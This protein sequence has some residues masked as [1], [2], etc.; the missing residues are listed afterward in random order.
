MVEEKSNT[1]S[2]TDVSTSST[3]YSIDCRINKAAWKK[4]FQSLE[5]VKN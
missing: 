2:A 5:K 1:E 4:V 3:E